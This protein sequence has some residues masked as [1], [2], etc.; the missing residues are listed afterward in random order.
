MD[1]LKRRTMGMRERDRKRLEKLRQREKDGTLSYTEKIELD[2]LIDELEEEEGEG[3]PI[4][5]RDEEKLDASEYEKFKSYILK[6]SAEESAEDVEKRVLKE[7]EEF[8]RRQAEKGRSLDQLKKDL[9][10]GKPR[11]ETEEEEKAVGRKVAERPERPV[12]K[13]KV[14][15]KVDSEKMKIAV[16]FGAGAL[17]GYLLKDFLEEGFEDD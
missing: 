5:P 12:P 11:P 8:E 6:R 15:D 9:D 7:T 2:L 14:E 13:R 16:A 4:P 1:Y 3:K 10:E 17:M